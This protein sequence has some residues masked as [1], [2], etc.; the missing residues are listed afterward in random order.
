MPDICYTSL[1]R[2]SSTDL[3][4]ASALHDC[5]SNLDDA[6]EE[7]CGSM[8]QMWQLGAMG[9]SGETFHFQMSNVQ[10]WMSVA[11]TNGFRGV[12]GGQGGVRPCR[13]GEEVHQQWACVG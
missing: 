10:T 12:G 4:A 3:R 5:L 2:Y 13:G 1:S 11:L 8:K 6:A 7:I 9:A